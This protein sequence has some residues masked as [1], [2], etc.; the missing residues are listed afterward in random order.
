MFT[1]PLARQQVARYRVMA[2]L[3]KGIADDPGKFTGD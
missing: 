2:A 3:L 1:W